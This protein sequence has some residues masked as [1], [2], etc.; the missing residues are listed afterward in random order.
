MAAQHSS[1]VEFIEGFEWVTYSASTRHQHGS[2]ILA[3]ITRVDLLKN[4]RT[5]IVATIGPVS[6]DLESV[7]RLV[8]A[9]VNMFRL[10]MSHGSHGDHALAYQN[11]RAVEHQ[12]KLP[13]A[14]L[15]DLCGPKI[16]TGRF[17]PG[18]IALITGSEVVVTMRDVPGAPGLIPSQYQALGEDVH[19]GDRILIADGLLELQVLNVAA[20]E[21]QCLVIHGG[22]LTDN[23]G[24]NLP[25]VQVSAP[26]MTDKDN[27][28][29][30]FALSLGVDYIALSFVR[31]AA[32][33]HVL[34]QLIGT[35]PLG[36]RIISKIEKPEA[37]INAED[38]LAASD[39]I[40][41]ARGDLGVE[42]PPEEVP[43]AQAELI[44]MARASG[45]PV[46]VATQMLESMIQHSRPTR[47]EVTDVSHAV[48]AGADA[49]MLSGE[50]AVGQFAVEAVEIMDRI[51]RQTEA[52]LWRQGAY[53]GSLSNL[54]PP[55]PLWNVIANATAHMSKELMAHAV[56]VISQSGLSA[57]AVSSA[58]PASPVVA[59]TGDERISRRMTLYWGVI[60][61]LEDEA[62]RTNPNELAR[63]VALSLGLAET[64]EFVLLIRGFN[65]AADLN[66]P[67]ITV[68]TV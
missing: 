68:I 22:Q 51:A 63:R 38:I 49:V 10:N 13:V 65:D 21:V 62:G 23:K 61:L 28:D 7:T 32:D 31:Q 18:G 50:T 41:I 6:G 25:G 27:A 9:G 33:V 59:I 42:L 4:R 53:G 39:A 20:T 8:K 26:S 2:S 15:A 60:P 19:T 35:D 66:S 56:M 46:I 34:R 58:R 52:H 67:S 57:A 55:L 45:K 43:V 3:I 24:I 44:Q 29:A 5:K 48:N 16:R 14:V 40:M 12:L 17:P 1:S 37:L 36:P 30:L 64:G 47:A 11:I 54:T